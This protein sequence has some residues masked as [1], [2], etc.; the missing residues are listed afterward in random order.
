MV[1]I[2]IA[3]VEDVSTIAQ[4]HAKSWQQH[5]RGILSDDYLNHQ[6][7]EERLQVWTKRFEEARPNQHILLAELNGQACGFACVVGNEDPH[8]GSLLDNIHVS[9]RLQ[10][11]GIGTILL[12]AAAKWSFEN[13]PDKRFYLLVYQQ[14]G[15]ALQF[16]QNL[17]GVIAARSL[18]DNPDGSKAMVVRVV[19]E[20]NTEIQ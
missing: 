11:Q 12:K 19:W 5:Y 16:Y 20:S 15:K 3:T 10:G 8:F 6:V 2:R 4:L 14:N 13:F 17:G 9:T 1:Q 7:E 18:M